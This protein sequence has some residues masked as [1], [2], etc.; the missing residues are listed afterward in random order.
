MTTPDPRYA[1]LPDHWPDSVKETHAVIEEAH[2]GLLT[3]EQQTTLYGACSMLATAEALDTQV[4][5]DGT[6]IINSRGAQALHPGLAEARMQRRTALAAIRGIAL[7]FAPA[8]ATAASAAGTALAAKRW[9][10]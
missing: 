4:R 6:M 9:R 3:P 10:S 5:A 7:K 2:E 8:S 1:G